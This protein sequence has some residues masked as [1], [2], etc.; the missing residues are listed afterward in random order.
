LRGQFESS[1]W[2]LLPLQFDRL[3]T[4]AANLARRMQVKSTAF[5]PR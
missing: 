3:C 5:R 4:H 2:I 1:D